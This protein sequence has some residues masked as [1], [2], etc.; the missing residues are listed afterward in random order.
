[1]VKRIKLRHKNADYFADRGVDMTDADLGRCNFTGNTEDK[2]KFKVPTLCNIEPTAPY[3]TDG[4]ADTLKKAVYDMGKY[5][6]GV[7]M[8]DEEVDAIK[9]FLKTLTGDFEG[10]PLS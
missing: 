1:M 5:Q 4:H 2:H 7:E 3:F 6:V 9:A 10:R 8:S